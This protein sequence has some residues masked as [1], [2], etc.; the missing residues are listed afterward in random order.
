M[1]LPDAFLQVDVGKQRPAPIIATAHQDSPNL[2]R[3]KESQRD[4]AR[5]RFFQQPASPDRSTESGTAPSSEAPKTCPERY[6]K[7][8]SLL[9]SDREVPF[10]ASRCTP[11]PQERRRCRKKPF[12]RPIRRP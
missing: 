12:G 2:D 6:R 10:R 9:R 7:I 11:L 5:K 4:K 3:V 8:T 1:V